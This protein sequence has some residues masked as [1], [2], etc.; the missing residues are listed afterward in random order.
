MAEWQSWFGPK[1]ENTT[2]RTCWELLN[3][4]EPSCFTLLKEAM[5]D[6]YSGKLTPE[7]AARHVQT[8]MAS[9]YAPLN[10]K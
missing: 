7:Q 2:Y 9:W 4:K 8:G 6:M 5:V 10:K 3:D 1:M